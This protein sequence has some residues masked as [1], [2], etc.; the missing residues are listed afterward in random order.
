V[1]VLCVLLVYTCWLNCCFVSLLFTGVYAL[2][3]I[4]YD[5]V[6][7]F[8]SLD[9]ICF[10]CFRGVWGWYNTEFCCFW[11]SALIVSTLIR[12]F[13]GN[14]R[15]LGVLTYFGWVSG[16]LVEFADFGVFWC[17]GGVWGWYN[18]GFRCFCV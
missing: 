3:F 7:V 15:F 10:C 9:L 1:A 18:T 13:A 2:V 6:G 8:Y 17:F 5:G 11:G 16:Y 14:L 4:V 12:C